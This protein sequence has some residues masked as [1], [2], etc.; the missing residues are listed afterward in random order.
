MYIAAGE[1]LEASKLALVQA[2]RWAHTANWPNSRKSAMFCSELC[3]ALDPM[4]RRS[5]PDDKATT[6]CRR[7]SIDHEGKGVAGEWLLDGVWTTDHEMGSTCIPIR[8]ECALECESSTSQTEFFKD[9]AKVLAVQAPVRL[10]YAGLNQATPS[11]AEEYISRRTKQVT[12]LLA[13]GSQS[14]VEGEWYLAFWPSP[15]KKENESLWSKL[16]R[17]L[18]SHLDQVSLFRFSRGEFAAVKEEEE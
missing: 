14:G 2:R 9:F 1:I 6:S 15:L 12:E 5:L 7:I 13:K 18:Y 10:F 16:D 3:D 8:I 4:I 17:G 11:K